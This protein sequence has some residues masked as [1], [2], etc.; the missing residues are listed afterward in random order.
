VGVIG[1]EGANMAGLITRGEANAGIQARVDA[2]EGIAENLDSLQASGK[3][4]GQAMVDAGQRLEEATT[5]SGGRL[6]DVVFQVYSPT[7]VIWQTG[8]LDDPRAVA[9]GGSAGWAP[10]ASFLLNIHLPETRPGDLEPGKTYSARAVA[11]DAE[12]T[13]VVPTTGGFY[14]RW[15]G[16]VIDTPECPGADGE[17][18]DMLQ[19]CRRAKQR[20]EQ[21]QERID[22]IGAKAERE[23]NEAMKDAPE[24]FRPEIPAFSNVLERDLAEAVDC[25][26]EA[27]LRSFNGTIEE[28]SGTLTGTVTI[29]DVTHTEI[30]GTFALRGSGTKRV[31][32]YEPVACR[33]EPG[34]ITGTRRRTDTQ[35]GPISVSGEIRAPNVEGG[36]FRVTMTTVEV[37]PNP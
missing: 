1:E 35:Q 24:Q 32:T 13:G 11:G 10:N 33:D 34:I 17:R 26:I 6:D 27:G 4:S 37:E 30:V 22:A 28:V 15:N 18:R 14:S 31:A 25:E 3:L 12:G 19:A 36:L 20:A 8:S 23:M 9:H 2:M 16:Q 5:P 29:T 21:M 7:A